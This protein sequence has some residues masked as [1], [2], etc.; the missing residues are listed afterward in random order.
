MLRFPVGMFCQHHDG[1]GINGQ[2]GPAPTG[3]G[4]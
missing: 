2:A 4:A 3:P 1:Q